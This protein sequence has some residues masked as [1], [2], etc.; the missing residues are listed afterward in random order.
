MPPDKT[1]AKPGDGGEE[2]PG[3]GDLTLVGRGG[4]G[5]VYKAR[6]E[7]PSRDVAIK[8]LAS[9][10]I[11]ETVLSRFQRECESTGRLTGHPNVVTVLDTGITRSGRPYVVTEYFEYGSLKKRLDEGGPFSAAE[12][13]R[14]GVKIAGAL[15]AAHQAKILHRDV[16][17]QNILLSRFGEPALADFGIARLLDSDEISTRGDV[18]TPY[19]VAPEVL[20]DQSPSPASD[21][22]SLA[23]TLYQLL[24]GEP[25][26]KRGGNEGIAP[27]LRRVLLEDPPEISRGDVPAQVTALIR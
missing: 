20:D 19:H 17:P 18:L 7:H 10:S 4:F 9:P 2:I 23:S 12:V 15:A 6:Q 25:A 1:P 8:I 26:F 16:K 14:I 11:D 27:V 13:L 22:Y 24:A 5:V 3:Y 21:T